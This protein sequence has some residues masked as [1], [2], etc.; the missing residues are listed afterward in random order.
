MK[1]MLF[2]STLY[3]HASDNSLTDCLATDYV[4][5]PLEKPIADANAEKMTEAIKALL[6]VRS[7]KTQALK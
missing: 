1:A 6:S 5:T 4:F 3:H 7:G 2:Q